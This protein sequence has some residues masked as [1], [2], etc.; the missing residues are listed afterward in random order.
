MNKKRPLFSLI[1][2]LAITF[3]IHLSGT[4]AFA[5]EGGGGWRP[6]YD[7][8]MKWLNFLI[9]AYA[10]VRFGKNP[11]LNFLHERKDKIAQE[12]KAIEDQK[13]ETDLKN[14]ETLDLINQG[15]QHIA[16]IK[17]KITDEG[18]RKKQSIID[19]AKKQSS[20]IIEK[21]KTKIEHLIY[22][23]QEKL[24]SELI[25]S[26]INIAMEKLPKEITNED[27]NRFLDNFLAYKFSK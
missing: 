12:I 6:T 26:A 23:E 11:M 13:Q 20:L 5:S 27:N 25:D 16:T 21:S 2:I 4:D 3:C 17:Q 24:K 8:V 19:D 15:E 18:E 10:I 9:L 7:L 22:S 1:L 14:Q